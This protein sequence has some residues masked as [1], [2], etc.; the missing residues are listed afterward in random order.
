MKKTKDYSKINL[1]VTTYKNG[2]TILEVTDPIAWKNLTIGAWC[3][4]NND[5]INKKKY[6]KLYN[7]YAVNDPRGLAPVGYYIPSDKEMNLLNL[8]RKP[9][10]GGYRSNNGT[11]YGIGYSGNWWSSSESGTTYAWYRFL[12]YTNGNTNILNNFY[13]DYGFSV[14]CLRDTDTLKKEM[15]KCKDCSDL[16]EDCTCIADTLD[17]DLT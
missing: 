4:Y 17:I 7:W 14:R 5:P 9:T 8:I 12:Y 1:D 6:G 3:Y 13:K 11:F 2:D 10:Y 15:L 16:L